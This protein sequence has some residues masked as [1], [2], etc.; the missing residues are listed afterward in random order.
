MKRILPLLVFVFLVFDSQA[1]IWR[2]NN[3][4]SIDADFFDL[5]S[6]ISGAAAGDTLYLGMSTQ[7]YGSATLS[8][9]LH[10]IG[11]GYFL[12]DNDSTQAI[13]NAS[14]LTSLTFNSGSEN[15]SIAGL[16]F[17]DQINV[18]ANNI[19]ILRC[20]SYYS[21][22]GYN[23][24][25]TSNVS[26]VLIFQ[27]FVHNYQ[28]SSS[29]SYRCLSLDGNNQN[30]LVSNNIFLRGNLGDNYGY[31]IYSPTNSSGVFLNNVVMG[32]WLQYNSLIQNNIVYSGNFSGSGNTINNNMC[33]STQF[34][35]GNGNIQNQAMGGVFTANGT[36]DKDA[37]WTLVTDTVT[38]LP[39]QT[40]NQVI[41]MYNSGPGSTVTQSFSLPPNITAATLSAMVRGDHSSTQEFGRFS[42][43]GSQIGGNLRHGFDNCSFN[44]TQLPSTNILSNVQGQTSVTLGYYIDPSVNYDP[45][46]CGGYSHIELSF[47]ITSGGGTVFPSV[48]VGG[49]AGGTDMGAFGGTSPY[50]LSGM[51]KIPSIFRAT[52]PSSTLSTDP[53]IFDFSSKSHK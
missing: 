53:F 5:S 45:G 1:K 40:V 13:Q 24:Q 25:I 28:G 2:V 4:G 32:Q 18:Q 36:Y 15:S 11:S 51:P 22:T 49:G 7:N 30:I 14:T 10:F 43:N 31:A 16:S 39:P 20:Y 17:T 12:A 38:G 6:A 50:V 8:K 23:F 35:A 44:G 3:S 34:P 41:N 26:N 19:A 37:Y 48:A 27:N 52:V 46:G 47:S 9:E 42:I 21:G 29:S 33:N